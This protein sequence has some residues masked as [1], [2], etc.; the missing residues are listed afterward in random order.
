MN[1]C[2][3]ASVD[4]LLLNYDPHVN[5]VGLESSVYEEMPYI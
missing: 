3:V 4:R 2:Q 5:N 1:A